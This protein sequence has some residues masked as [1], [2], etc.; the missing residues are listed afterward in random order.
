MA[1]RIA[2]RE[3]GK[4]V[5]ETRQENYD[6]FDHAVTEAQKIVEN[7]GFDSFQVWELCETFTEKT[8]FAPSTRPVP[9]LK[10]TSES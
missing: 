1:H 3:R 7:S 5:Y 9:Q 4:S 8:I 2:L 10:V 6:S